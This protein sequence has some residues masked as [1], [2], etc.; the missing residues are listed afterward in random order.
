MATSSQINPTMLAL[1]PAQIAQLPP[2]D[3]AQYLRGLSP[4]MQQLYAHDQMITANRRFMRE[5]V[6]R[7]AYC[8]VTGGSGTTAAYSSGQTL[9]FDLPKVPGY[10]KGVLITYN[11]TVTPAAG[12]GATYAVNKAAPFSIFSRLEIDYNGAQVTTHPYFAC[13][14]MDQ[15]NGFQNGAQNAVIAGNNDAT[16]AANIVGSTPITVGVGNTWTGKM[17]LRLNAL[18]NDTVPGVLP[19]NGV[20]NSPQI[21]LTCA[22]SFVG[23]DPLLNPI[24]P[25]AGTGHSST[26]VTGNINVDVIYLDG[27]NLNTPT[28]LQ[29][30]WQ[31][32][33]TIQYTWESPLTPFSGCA[34]NQAKTISSKLKHWYVC[35]IIIDANQSNQFAQ[36]S[37]ITGF[38]LSPD[39][40]GQQNFFAFNLS[41]NVSI[42][43]F[44]DRYIRRPFGQ[45]VDNGVIPWVTGPGR[46]VIDST[47]RNGSQFLNMYNGG[48]PAATHLYQV[49]SVGSLTTI[50]G[51]PAPTPRVETFL[52]S[53]NAAGLKV[54]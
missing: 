11:L 46:G 30:N 49:S 47:N 53:E 23:Q 31:Q 50:D 44:Y 15:L 54:S 3:Q 2:Q 41:N 40:V 25:V 10:A 21:K 51:Y 14:V 18:G 4:A 12:T 32:E 27:T 20:G 43:D 24:A 36:L 19:I 48:F 42:Y 8:P 13:K 33:P 22:P 35:S 9:F 52:V 17:Y 26:T 37:N 16:I 1:T 34:V 28:P 29:L 5:S 6:E 7:V 39:A 38:M 45:D